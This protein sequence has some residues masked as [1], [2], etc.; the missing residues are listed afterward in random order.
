MNK[1]RI[2]VYTDS[3][4]KRRIALAAAKHE[5]SVAEYCLAAIEQQLTDDDILEREQ[6]DISVTPS[7]HGAALIADLRQ[8]RERIATERRGALIDLDGLFDELHDER[9]HELFGVR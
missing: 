5:T 8:L 1:Q 4:T 6:I 3:E 9:D 2:Q 7:Q